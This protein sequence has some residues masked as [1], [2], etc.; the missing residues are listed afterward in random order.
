M[1]LSTRRVQLARR[2]DGL[3][4]PGDFEV[5][6]LPR[7]EPR[8]GQ[9]LV[10]NLWMSV[11]PYM[12]RSMEPV[13]K[14][15]EPWPIGGA[16]D[17]PSIGRVIASRN[18]KFAE[19]DLVESM[20]GWQEHFISSGADFIPYLTPN[21]ALAKRSAPGARP[22]DWLGFLGIA[23]MTA[24]AAMACL[25]KAKRGET[26]VISSGA[27]TV[28]SIACQIGRI[29]GLRVVTSAGADDKVKWLRDVARV[30][31]AF[32]Y[33]K[34]PIAEALTAAC[35]AGIDLLLENA[36]PEHMSACLPL[37]NELKQ[38]LI[39]GFIS[40][41]N[42]GGTIPGIDNFQYVL[43]KFLTVQAFR[44]MDSLDAYDQFVADMLRWRAAGD[45]VL[46]ETI[47]DGIETA[48]AALCSLFTGASFGKVLVRIA[49][50]PAD[51]A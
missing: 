11:D 9:I 32:N 39:T 27:G 34:Q 14:D 8:D 25:S 7:P 35:P 41:Y 26:A 46:P 44:F 49:E 16:L 50:D 17:G 43:D 31:H 38:I 42:T 21:D 4:T 20:S 29:N 37:M 6:S 19:G 22:R 5:V 10:H 13:A 3:A 40:I 45:I 1:A 15:L 12:R 36:S 30:D 51:A 24:Y 18:P 47:H 48:P 23:A 2:P 28:G 33:K